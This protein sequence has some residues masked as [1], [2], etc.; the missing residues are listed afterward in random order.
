MSNYGI[1]DTNIS[2]ISV[3]YFQ[4][5]NT[6]LL[7]SCQWRPSMYDMQKHI[8]MSPYYAYI[9]EHFLRKADHLRSRPR[10]SVF[11]KSP[12]PPP[13]RN[14]SYRYVPDTWLYLIYV[15]MWTNT[16]V[17]NKCIYLKFTCLYKYAD[18]TYLYNIMQYW[19]RWF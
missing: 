9:I 13:L 8:Q 19:F 3:Q 6:L 17:M 4:R 15:F 18:L 2:K 11:V 16:W 10:K 14:N 1:L 5:C 12:P 7:R